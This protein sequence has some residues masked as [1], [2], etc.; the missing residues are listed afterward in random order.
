MRKQPEAKHFPEIT[1]LSKSALPRT[2]NLFH[3]GDLIKFQLGEAIISHGL[4][5][6]RVRQA[7]FTVF[8]PK[9]SGGKKHLF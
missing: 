9:K 4:N 2:Q 7:T 6:H 5:H 3:A 1:Q 8:A